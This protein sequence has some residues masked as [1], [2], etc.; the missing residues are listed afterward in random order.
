MTVQD[1][2]PRDH[3]PGQPP[4]RPNSR[5]DRLAAQLRANLR[6][7]KDQARQRQ[8]ETGQAEMGQA[9]MGQAETDPAG[10]EPK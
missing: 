2:P 5:K 4:A 1:K 9:E 3:R 8:A 7:R 6:R 10:P